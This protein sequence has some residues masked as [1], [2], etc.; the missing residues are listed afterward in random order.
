MG[1][2]NEAI[3]VLGKMDSNKPAAAIQSE[4]LQE[5]I[6]KNSILHYIFCLVS[7]LLGWHLGVIISDKNY[8]HT[9][10]VHIKT[11]LKK[12]TGV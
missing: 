2:S 3:N 9:N 5:I 12:L 8:V 1:S 7:K 10:N 11:I 6:S 4:V